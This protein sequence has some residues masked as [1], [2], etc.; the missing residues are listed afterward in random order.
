MTPVDDTQAIDRRVERVLDKRTSWLREQLPVL[1]LAG[2]VLMAGVG[3]YV[4]LHDVE[5]VQ[6][7]H[8]AVI[9][10]VPA[11]ERRIDVIDARAQAAQAETTRR[12]DVIERKLDVL[13]ERLLG[14]GGAK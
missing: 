3:L 13:T 8:S 5:Q 4:R 10:T 6:R 1:S 9:E 7:R 2:A 14:H 12:L 11:L